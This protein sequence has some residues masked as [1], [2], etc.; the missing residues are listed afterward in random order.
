MESFFMFTYQ[1]RPRVFRIDKNRPLPFP[2][3]GKVHFHFAPLQPFGMEASGG[4]TA[5]QGVGAK[6]LFDANTGVHTIESKSPLQPLEVILEEPNR[7]IQMTGNMLTISQSFESNRELTQIIEG[8]YFAIPLLLNVEFADP[9]VIERVEGKIG[10]V[11]FRWELL[12]WK[13]YFEIITQH[14]QQLAVAS[15]WEKMGLLSP[16]SR[17]RL[18]AALHYFYVAIRLARQ[19]EIVG[20]FL[21]EMILNLSKVL[22]VLFPPQGDGLK[23]EAARKGLAKLDFSEEEIEADYIPAMALR[24]EI[25]VGHV[26]L[27]LYKQND[28]SLIHGYVGHAERAYRKLLQRILTRVEAGKYEVAPYQRSSADSKAVAVID[29]LRRYA[30]RYQP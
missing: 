15:S 8:I 21:S 14:K 11:D 2:S 3:D 10:D 5:V 4:R 12:D 13:M 1:I 30:D 18:L 9:P 23:R 24:N 25:D 20:E 19:G 22:E 17:S 6:A 7:T 16:P 28:L 27:S 29:K 26:D